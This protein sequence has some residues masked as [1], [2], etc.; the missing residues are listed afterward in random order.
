MQMAFSI[1]QM[2][3]ATHCGDQKARLYVKIILWYNYTLAS[4][5]I[6]AILY[7]LLKKRLLVLHVSQIGLKFVVLCKLSFSRNAKSKNSFMLH[8]SICQHRQ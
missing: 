4:K 7:H 6:C 3:S 5:G 2:P 1:I 8:G